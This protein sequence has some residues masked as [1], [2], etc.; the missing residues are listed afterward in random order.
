[1]G[2]YGAANVEFWFTPATGLY[3]GASFESL[4]TY[5]QGLEG[6]RVDIDIGEGLAVRAGIVYRF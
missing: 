4:D 6:R 5:N 2:F 1:M 3:V